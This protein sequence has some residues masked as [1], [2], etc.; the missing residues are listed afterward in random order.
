MRNVETFSK[1]L[2]QEYEAQYPRSRAAH[3]E[4]KRLLVDGVSHGARLFASF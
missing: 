2:Y 3:E 1:R 4:A